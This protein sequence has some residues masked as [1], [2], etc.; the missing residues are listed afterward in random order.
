MT[1]TRQNIPLLLKLKRLK[2]SA[3]AE[4]I[5]SVF[6]FMK[7][8]R[9][10]KGIPDRVLLIRNDRIGDAVVTLPVIR[11]IKT[12]Y[13]GMRVDV[14]VSARNK[15]VFEDF[16][17]ADDVIEFDWA[18]PEAGKLYEWPL[19]GSFLQFIR[20]GAAPYV[21][22][23][24]FRK[25]IKL[26][27]SKK[28][29]AAADLVGLFRNALLCR[30]ISRFSIG[31]RKFGVYIAYSYYLD[32]NWVTDRDT[33]FM[34]N[35]IEHALVDALGLSF[36]KEDT[37][38]PFLDISSAGGNSPSYDVIF[39]I[40]ASK[41]R[42]LSIEKEKKLIELM[43]GMKLLVIDSAETPNFVELKNSFSNNT[44]I[45]FKIFNSLRDA[46]AECR[47]SKLLLC[48]DGGQA[49]YLSQFMKTLTIFGPGSAALWKPFEFSGYSLLE[50]T[51]GVQV[52]R[53]GG[54]FGHMAVYMPIWCRPC[55]YVG[56]SQKPCL[57]SI[58]SEFL[59]DIINKYCLRDD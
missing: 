9:K 55:F 37:T 48:Y 25:K 39:H 49:H 15:F 44:N 47:N 59:W 18:P 29:D 23:K 33:D 43:S 30:L 7:P 38:L 1:K 50:E 22:S 26:L 19:L 42:K 45:T 31:P 17:Y 56:C 34:T 12:N 24:S 4:K 51:N 20:Y 53:S 52:H 14:L 10:F 13:P 46:A 3:G 21:F 6:S 32:T 16:K 27:K 54:K 58:E 35:K 11:N 2:N 8:R 28:Y 41:I 40:G 57:S 5:N 36:Q